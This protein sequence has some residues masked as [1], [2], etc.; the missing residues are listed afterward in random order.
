MRVLF[1]LAATALAATSATAVT[2][3]TRVSA[4][5]DLTCNVY[6]HYPDNSRGEL[7]IAWVQ[8]DAG[9]YTKSR[10]TDLDAA[11]G[12]LVRAGKAAVLAFDKP[13]IEAD[14]AAPTGFRVDEA[15]VARVTGDDL[16]A[17]AMGA[18]SWAMNEP[19]ASLAKGLAF[20][21]HG[22]GSA[23]VARAYER[24]LA[25]NAVWAKAV[26]LVELS[27][28]PLGQPLRRTLETLAESKAPA[29]FQLFQGLDDTA[30]PAAEVMDFESW[31]EQRLAAQQ[32]GLTLGVRY[33]QA[34]HELNMSAVND[35]L[36][37][38]LTYFD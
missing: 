12:Y 20:H 10:P 27:S 26:R 32:P 5:A 14:V 24:A 37:A 28:L 6:L 16:V 23:V 17:C 18:V 22:T 33:Y 11:A 1:V 7:P 35:M 30:A 21:G 34:G 25:T 13:G 9:T 4:S 8:A 29:T 15:V 38:W 36:F 2:L 19:A 31:N 3:K